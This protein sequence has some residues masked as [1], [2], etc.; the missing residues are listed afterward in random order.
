MPRPAPVFVEVITSLT[1]VVPTS[2]N[3]P[4]RVASVPGVIETTPIVPPATAPAAV[5]AAVSYTHLTLP[6]KL[7]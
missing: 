7:L 3:A 5:Y 2:T 1:S 4:V 6:T